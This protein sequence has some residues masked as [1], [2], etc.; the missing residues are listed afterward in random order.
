MIWQVKGDAPAKLS[1]L[2]TINEAAKEK[3]KR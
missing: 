3:K 1:L 2:Q